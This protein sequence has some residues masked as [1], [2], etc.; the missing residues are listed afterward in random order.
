MEASWIALVIASAGIH[1]VR[2]LLLKGG[3]SPNGRYFLYALCWI[4][5]TLVH[6]LVFEQN[7]S[8]PPALWQSVCLS[9]LGLV[10]YYFGTFQAL[11]VSDL[12]IY[13]PI[14]RCSPV[15]ILLFSFIVLG[16]QYS[17]LVVV[18]ILMIFVGTIMLQKP[19]GGIFGNRL[20]LLAAVLAMVG[21]AIY[22]I[23]DAR[24]M[25][26]VEPGAYLF[27]IYLLVSAGLLVLLA[28]D[29]RFAGKTGATKAGGPND[30]TAPRR[31]VGEIRASLS[32]RVPVAAA[33]SYAAYLLVL[34]AFAMGGEAAAVSAVRQASIPVS[35]LMGVFILRESG[36]S[37]RFLW[38]IVIAAGI[39]AIGLFGRV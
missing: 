38:A 4:P 19:K 6:G 5:M 29:T 3:S 28:I 21:S 12:S 20:A 13:Y 23:V 16:V 15:A 25:Q 10:L 30:G 37:R 14:I 22:T 11:R 39:A 31:V 2:D 32:W 34:Q 1:P 18:S 8:L 26:S 27:Y 17:L 24:A 7:L 36:L 9:A 33:T 35:V